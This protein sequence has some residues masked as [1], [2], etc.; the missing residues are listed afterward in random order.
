ML[1]RMSIWRSRFFDSLQG[2]KGF[3]NRLGYELC[4]GLGIMGRV[5]AIASPIFAAWAIIQT[6]ELKMNTMLSHRLLSLNNN[7]TSMASNPWENMKIGFNYPIGFVVPFIIYTCVHRA[8]A[9]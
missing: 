6:Y 8:T 3:L 4:N 5:V 9:V 7:T 1:D 2:K